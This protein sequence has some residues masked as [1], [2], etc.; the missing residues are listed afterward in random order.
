MCMT[1]LLVANDADVECEN[2][3]I[4]ILE[5]DID[6]TEK[7]DQRGHTPR[8]YAERNEKVSLEALCCFTNHMSS[9]LFS[10]P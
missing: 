4:P 1:A 9:F 10:S 3:E 6:E 8:D 7:C 2:E 5:S